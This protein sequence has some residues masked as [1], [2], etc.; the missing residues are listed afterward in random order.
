MQSF[1]DAANQGLLDANIAAVICN[2]PKAFGLER[3]ANA[4]IP[5]ELIDHTEFDDRE[6]FDAAL[7]ER[8]D[9]YQPDLVILAGF[10][11]ILTPSFVKHYL[12]RMFNI[13]PSLLPKYPGLNTHQ[14]AIDAGDSQAGATVHFVTEELDGG[15]AIIQARL[16]IQEG[17]NAS[18]LAKRTL[19]YE[20]KIY[21]RAAQWFIENRLKLVN[22]CA[23]LDGKSLSSSGHVFE[24]SM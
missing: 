2:R 17:D 9:H 23:M 15:P 12:G 5:A 21:P 4:G 10:M 13:H 11:R 22:N 14:R 8:I 6:S 20:H 7:I 3:A 18:T 1:V 24:D 16:A 19:S